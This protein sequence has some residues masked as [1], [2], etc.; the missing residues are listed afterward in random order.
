M[1]PFIS[2]Q[3]ERGSGASAQAVRPVVP[4]MY[5]VSSPAMTGVE[6]TD[7]VGVLSPIVSVASTGNER[8]PESHRHDASPTVPQFVPLPAHIPRPFDPPSSRSAIPSAF[9]S[10]ALAPSMNPELE[11]IP[12]P[13]SHVARPAPLENGSLGLDQRRGQPLIEPT[14]Q[15]E[16]T[17]QAPVP[18][19][20]AIHARIDDLTQRLNVTVRPPAISSIVPNVPHS[21][22]SETATTQPALQ[23]LFQPSIHEQRH[24][25]GIVPQQPVPQIEPVGTAAPASVVTVSIGRIEFRNSLARASTLPQPAAESPKPESRVVSLEDYLRHRTA[26]GY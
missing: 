21:P 25:T 22:Q 3:L 17:S 20:D 15:T 13:S 11:P 19:L 8:Q 6:A 26:S 23:A 7:P 4:S 1:I 5:E 24:P 18:P 14:D 9:E 2:T 16:R 12:L 10:P